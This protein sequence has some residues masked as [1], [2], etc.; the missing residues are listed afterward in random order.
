MFW[1]IAG[2]ETRKPRKIFSVKTLYETL[3]TERQPLQAQ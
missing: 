3:E 2:H 1:D